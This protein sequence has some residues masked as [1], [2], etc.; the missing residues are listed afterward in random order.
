M[1]LKRN[2]RKQIILLCSLLL[3]FIFTIITTSNLTHT[4]SRNFLNL[5]ED[6]NEE[7]LI[8]SQDLSADNTYEG[9]GAPWNITHWA[10]RTDAQLYTTFDEGETG[11]IQFPL[12]SDWEAYKIDAKIENLYDTRNWNNGTF[13][14]GDDDNS[15]GCPENDTSDV[16]NPFQSWTFYDLDNPS[17]NND[18]SGNYLD[19]SAPLSA[20]H[21]CLELRMNGNPHVAGRYYYQT[22][23]KCW[24]ESSFQVPR[25][26]VID[27]NLRFQLN[28]VHLI[29]FNSWEL[30]ISIN[31]IRVFTIGIY[32][33]K[34]MGVN[35]WHD[36]SVPQGIWTNTTN[37]FS[38]GFLNDTT[39]SIEVALEYSANSASYGFEDGENTDYQQILVDNVLLETT[40]E[41]QPSDLGLK[42]NGTTIVDDDWG[43]GN[44]EI[45]GNWQSIN[46]KLDL[47][48]SSD[49]LSELG[50]YEIQCLSV[51]NL[52]AIKDLPESNYET[53]EDSIGTSFSATNN[54]VV[55]WVCYGRIKVPTRYEQTLMKVEF[56]QDITITAV[57]DPQNPD[58]NILSQCDNT[59]AGILL[60]PV[61]S[62][63]DTPDGFWRFKAISPNYGENL[64]IY[65]NSTGI[66]VEDYEYLSGE[67]VNITAQISNTGIISS[68]IQYTTASLTIRFPNNTIWTEL[69]QTSQ[70]DSSGF[71]KFESFQ[72][73]STPPDYEVGLYETIL[74]WNNSHSGFGFNES[75]II[76]KNF[77]VVH[78]SILTPE[79]NFYEDNYENTTINLKISFNDAVT[80]NPIQAANVYT[81]DFINPGIEQ[82]FGE[83]SQGF[84][85]LE[86]N[87]TAA[88]S[89][90]NTVTIYAESNNY[91]NK[92]VDIVIEVI[93]RTNL[94]VDDDFIEDAQYNS[95]FTIQIDYTDN[96]TGLGVD[97]TEL[98]S[99][100]GGDN[101]F[102]RISQGRYNLICNASGGSYIA[103]NLY[104]FNIYAGAYQYESQ[105]KTIR[106]YI[107]ELDSEIYLKLNDTD[108][109]PNAVYIVQV[110]EQVNITIRYQD[111]FGN[112]ISGATVNVSSQ[113][114]ARP[115][116]EDFIYDQYSI[117]LNAT[118][119]G[120][121]IDN[122]IVYAEKDNYKP[123]SIPFIF[124]IIERQTEYEIY[125]NGVN[126]TIDPFESVTVTSTLNITVRYYDILGAYIPEATVSLSG[127]YSDTLTEISVYEQY[128]ILID[129]ADLAIGIRSLQLIAY[130]AN[131]EQQ[132]DVIRIQVRRI[133]LEINTTSG[134]P[135][136]IANLNEPVSIN[137]K[138]NDLIGNP[139]LGASVNYSW[140]F[141]RGTLTDAD[142]DGV[143]EANL[144]YVPEGTYTIIISAYVG[145][146]YD[147]PSFKITLTVIRPPEDLLFV[148]I[149]LISTIVAGVS[150]LGYLIL[151]MRVLKYPKPV[152]KVRK[153]KRTLK[154]KNIPRTLIEPREKA[155]KSAY[156]TQTSDS[157]RYLK[158]KPSEEQTIIDKMVK[159]SPEPGSFKELG[160]GEE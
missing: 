29:S 39:I 113:S 68:Y 91:V 66:W 16:S 58:L 57:Y 123:N 46:D 83:I 52:F 107:T 111:T 14:Y 38:S 18:M 103:G 15:Y 35:M 88:N 106:V 63:S 120:Q 37:V 50:S 86:F 127:D 159:S 19:S 43:I 59:T 76:Y 82:Y 32:S 141:G 34:S 75:G 47:S 30:T 157:K 152:R 142:N 98:I 104:S 67:Y 64:V 54:S 139:L 112:H 108:T 77:R 96:E 23:D 1:R 153:Y 85:F 122:L 158:G 28:P 131:Y 145:D 125:I 65:S 80:N 129:T 21:E 134:S 55:E 2:S 24:W 81:Y 137:I 26:R 150:L 51:I 97:P 89:G 93:K 118:E 79:S 155:I 154:S 10:N 31:N 136:K 119:L 73:P 74:T 110:W 109:N 25:G 115:L 84:Y 116:E 44:V 130:R 140:V 42:L 151:Y 95:N 72:I 105:M 27:N 90:N 20:G 48:F 53:N 146:N 70:P 133:S 4:N 8:N 117:L 126:K 33:L 13:Q 56:P 62:I 128:T 78:D 100:W 40:A 49:D 135:I 87:L 61:N 7:Y 148:M 147:I 12:F 41:A 94:D 60:I 17:Y 144:G 99:D 149:A 36:F 101:H 71:V 11:I 138:L 114:F 45:N 3:G 160:G 5:D 6:I 132:S 69:S 92:Q 22:G 124:E 156:E 102:T 143:Y 121:G 9:I